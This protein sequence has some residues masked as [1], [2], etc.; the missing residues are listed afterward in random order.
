MR[1]HISGTTGISQAGTENNRVVS[2]DEWVAER[3]TL[4]AREKELTRLRDQVARER[5]ALPWVRIDK[6]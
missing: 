2:G 5:R 3:K 1:A 4:L 6:N